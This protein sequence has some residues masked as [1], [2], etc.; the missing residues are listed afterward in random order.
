MSKAWKCRAATLEPDWNVKRGH[1]RPAGYYDEDFTC[2]A[3]DFFRPMIPQTRV[4]GWKKFCINRE[5]TCYDHCKKGCTCEDSETGWCEMAIADVCGSNAKR[6]T[7]NPDLCPFF[8]ARTKAEWRKAALCYEVPLLTDKGSIRGEAIAAKRYFGMTDEEF[9][10][11]VKDMRKLIA[12]GKKMWAE[13]HES[14][15]MG[16]GEGEE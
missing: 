4:G 15:R 12:E 10:G 9:D 13:A 1:L 6:C 11:V 3:K 16:K 5:C 7:C 2:A 14:V 8:R